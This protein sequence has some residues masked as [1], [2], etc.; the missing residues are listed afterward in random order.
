MDD[1]TDL[2]LFG[3]PANLNFYNNAI[4]SGSIY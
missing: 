3:S 4:T 2:I 1:R